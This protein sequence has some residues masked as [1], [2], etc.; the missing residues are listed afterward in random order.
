MNTEIAFL[1]NSNDKSISNSLLENSTIIYV[2]SSETDNSIYDYISINEIY[3]IKDNVRDN[4]KTLIWEKELLNYK[5]IDIPFGKALYLNF[6]YNIV[7][8]LK[9]VK[10]VDNILKDKIKTIYLSK[11]IPLFIRNIIKKSGYKSNK[12]I[13]EIGTNT[14][15]FRN[16]KFL[17][18]LYALI[19]KPL[20]MLIKSFKSL[21]LVNSRKLL[22]FIEHQRADFETI[23]YL[24]KNLRLNRKYWIITS[25]PEIS[26]RFSKYTGTISIEEFCSPST[27]ISTL[28]TF[29]NLY[30]KLKKN[31]QNI[32]KK[33][34]IPESF[35]K[36]LSSCSETHTISLIRTIFLINEVFNKIKPSMIITGSALHPRS[37]IFSLFAQTKGI[38][39]AV[40]QHGVTADVIG[41]LPQEAETFFAWGDYSKNWMISNGME[42]SR[43]I[44]TGSPKYEYLKEKLKRKSDNNELFNLTFLT[45][46]FPH[47]ERKEYTKLTIK[48]LEEIP[49]LVIKIK[50]HPAEDIEIYKKYASKNKR[51]KLI[52]K[53]MNVHRAM[54][55]SDGVIATNTGAGIEALIAGYDLIFLNITGRKELIPY[56]EYNSAIEVKDEREFV[57]AIG[58]CKSGKLNL[59]EGRKSFIKGY[60]NNLEG[61]SWEIIDEFIEDTLYD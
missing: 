13:I 6:F 21:F 15:D 49:D 31:T 33:F 59:T 43:I 3:N 54:E 46:N 18:I 24:L 51:L 25:K 41:Y 47:N 12:R 34:N 32:L 58:L 19:L 40:V 20:Y 61:K 39:S 44:I 30:S 23:Y 17:L 56:S 50:P 60:L 35:L 1:W 48:A 29:F 57:N 28:L 9:Y 4:L 27:I 52:D 16:L 5:V 26:R 10:I 53:K 55:N 36:N 11:K 14:I 45:S 2:D 42:Q 37:I 8:I 38:N 22:F 7:D